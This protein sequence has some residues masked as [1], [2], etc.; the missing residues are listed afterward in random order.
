MTPPAVGKAIVNILFFSALKIRKET[1]IWR[2]KKSWQANSIPYYWRRLWWNT[3]FRQ[4]NLVLPSKYWSDWTGDSMLL[5]VYFPQTKNMILTK[6][7]HRSQVENPAPSET[8]MWGEG[9]TY[10]LF[11]SSLAWTEGWL[12]SAHTINPSSLTSSD[13]TWWLFSG[14]HSSVQLN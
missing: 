4:Y 11:W 6:Y 9:I 13:S 8:T 3:E 1:L 7:S 12:A 5:L 10:S 14:G 2:H